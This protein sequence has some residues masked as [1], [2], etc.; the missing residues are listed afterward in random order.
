G[1][2]LSMFEMLP[3]DI[4]FI[5]M[6]Y[7]PQPL[8]ALLL[9]SKTMKRI[10][11][12]FRSFPLYRPSIQCIEIAESKVFAGKLY[13]RVFR[14]RWTD[15]RYNLFGN[16]DKMGNCVKRETVHDGVSDENDPQVCKAKKE[17]GVKVKLLNLEDR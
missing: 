14:E 2:Q 10:V 6:N 9:T 4:L 8:G 13:L 16:I 5:I 7:K 1:D 12:E 11:L 15:G 3:V 17:F